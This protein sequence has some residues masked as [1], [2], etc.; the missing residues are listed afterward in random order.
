MEYEKGS[1]K[2]GSF[3][4]RVLKISSSITVNT[5]FYFNW[6]SLSTLHSIIPQNISQQTLKRLSA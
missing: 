3:S 1:W 2:S 4:A 5:K 6:N